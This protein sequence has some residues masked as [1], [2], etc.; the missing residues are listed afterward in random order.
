MRIIGLR[1]TCLFLQDHRG[2]FQGISHANWGA[3][4]RPWAAREGKS[5]NFSVITEASIR[6]VGGHFR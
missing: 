6:H 2:D 1:V 3:S 5:F 4:R